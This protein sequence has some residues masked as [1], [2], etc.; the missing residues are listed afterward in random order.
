MSRPALNTVRE[1][2]AIR[3]IVG[4]RSP[5]DHRSSSTECINR[6]RTTRSLSSDVAPQ[7][8]SRSSCR[9]ETCANVIVGRK[10]EA[11]NGGRRTT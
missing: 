5:C 8:T 11:T 2:R 9:T 3:S 4:A 6:P 7:L 10:D 1:V